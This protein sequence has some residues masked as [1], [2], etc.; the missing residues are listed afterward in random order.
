MLETDDFVAHTPN[1]VGAWHLLRNHLEATASLTAA[2]AAKFGAEDLG[3]IAGLLH[4][5]GKYQDDFQSYLR[6]CA[7]APDDATSHRRGPPHA[8]IG[9]VMAATYWDGLAFVVAGHHA[10]LGKRAAITSLLRDVAD[11]PAARQSIGRAAH[12]LD[13][14]ANQPHTPPDFVRTPSEAEMFLR[15][16]FSCVVDADRLDAEAHGSQEKSRMRIGYPSPSDLVRTFSG[17]YGK[18]AENAESNP[19]NQMRQQVYDACV[20]AAA[21]DQGVFRL[22]VPTGG[23]KTLSSMAFALTHAQR[24]GLERIIVAAPFTSIVDQTAD[25]YRQVLG[26]D[27]VLEHQSAISE[28]DGADESMLR[29]DLRRRLATENWD[30]PVVVTTTV[31][32]FESLFSNRPGACRKLH[33]LVRSVIILD[34]V[35]TLPVHLLEAIVSVL[36]EL[37]VHYQVTVVLCSATQPALSGEAHYVKGFA[38]V[39]EIVPRSEELFR[40]HRRVEYH[41]VQAPWTWEEVAA[42][43]RERSQV[44]AILNTR[45]DALAVLAA[46][47][48]PDAFHLSTLLYPMHRRRVLNTIKQQLR[49]GVPC[50][51]VSTQVVEA[52]VDIDFPSVYRAVGPLDRIVQAAGRCN[53]EGLRPSGDV[54]VFQPAQGKTPRGAYGTGTSEASLMLREGC[55]LHDPSVYQHYFQRLF[56]DIS[57]AK[58]QRI[59]RL[60]TELAFPEVADEFRMIEDGTVSVV[61]RHGPDTAKVDALLGDLYAGGAPRGIHRALAPFSVNIYSHEMRQSL[62]KGLVSERPGGVYLWEGLYDDTLGI[63]HTLRDPAD[64]IV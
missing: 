37:V 53:R 55:D 47:D 12:R 35:Q 33:N 38:G 19:V 21:D 5:V 22:T 31:Q 30:A 7:A 46:L 9:A 44:L 54:T 61:I 40:T 42:Q 64:L 63:Q 62:R 51:L 26:S 39:R 23:G 32:L 58:S 48:D 36:R 25:A 13:L 29:A 11:S 10:G 15:M 2:R 3:R 27:A 14:P 49:R 18:L 24:H 57:Q 6:L 1:A 60:R 16:L 45:P 34:E 17:R 59:E 41:I 28:M 4:D 56:D 52:G 43:L 20:A 8:A 50:R